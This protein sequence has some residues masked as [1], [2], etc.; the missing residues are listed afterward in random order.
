MPDKLALQA[1]LKPIGILGGT[2]DPIHNGHIELAHHV[3]TLLPLEKI[4]FI[5]CHQP[6]LNKLPI[7]SPQQRLDMLTIA[8]Q[9][10]PQYQVDD[11][12]IRRRGIS[13]AIDTLLSLKKDY[14]RQPLCFIVGWDAFSRFNQWHQWVKI[15]DHT[16]LIVINRPDTNPHL[17]PEIQAFLSSHLVEQPEKLIQSLAGSIYFLNIPPIPISST[18]IR[19]KLAQQRSLDESIPAAVATYIHQHHLYQPPPL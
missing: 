10:F 2:F 19:E 8:L 4:S 9:H 6:A 5:P 12:E 15:L 7:A 3:F 11:R 16:H 18:L 1:P 13:Y 17:S 14:P